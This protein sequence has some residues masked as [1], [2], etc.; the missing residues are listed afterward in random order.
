MHGDAPFETLDGRSKSLKGIKDSFTKITIYKDFSIY[1]HKKLDYIIVGKFYD[2]DITNKSRFAI[3]ADMGFKES[4]AISYNKVFR[5]K[6]IIQVETIHVQQAMRREKIA[7]FLYKYLLREYNIMSD[8]IQYENA[9]KMW[10]NFIKE[11]DNTI[12]LYNSVEDKIITKITNNSNPNYIWKE[13]PDFE[14]HK[15]QLLMVQN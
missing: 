5:K 1:K 12:Y 15:Y 2:D 10:K 14:K 9:V 4:K 11:T 6:N 7:S 13:F 8:K 3:V